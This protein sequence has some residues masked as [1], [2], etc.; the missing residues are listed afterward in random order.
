MSD[1]SIWGERYPLRRGPIQEVNLGDA[2]WQK[3]EETV[4]LSLSADVRKKIK[5]W[6]LLYGYVGSIY[7]QS[8]T[9]LASEFVPKLRSW[10]ESTDSLLETLKAERNEISSVEDFVAEFLHETNAT[11]IRKGLPLEF[12]VFAVQ[13]ASAVGA[14]VMKQLTHEDRNL[15][16]QNDLWS[17]WVC[18]TKQELEKAG[19]KISGASI[20]KSHDDSPS[21]FINAIIELQSLLPLECQHFKGYESVRKGTQQSLRAMGTMTQDTLLQLMAGWGTQVHNGYPGSLRQRSPEEVQEFDEAA[22]EIR[23]LLLD[24][25]RH[26]PQ[27]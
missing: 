10:L 17:A 19:V 27:S 11:E 18:L 21:P 9:V 16:I 1:S 5:A 26:P 7:S 2:E 13:S 6:A 3:L 23:A 8:N 22:Q 14:F 4:G 24:R 15:P 12:L 20:D 25:H